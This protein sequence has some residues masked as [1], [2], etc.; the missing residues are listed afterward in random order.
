VVCQLGSIEAQKHR[1]LC[2]PWGHSKGGY[3]VNSREGVEEEAED[4]DEMTEDPMSRE[5]IE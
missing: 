1:E 4:E 3:F 2:Q 5:V